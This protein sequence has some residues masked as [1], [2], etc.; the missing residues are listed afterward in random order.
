MTKR[1]KIKNCSKLNFIKDLQRIKILFNYKVIGQNHTQIHKF[2][3][4]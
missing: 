4:V 2:T 1:L 3:K